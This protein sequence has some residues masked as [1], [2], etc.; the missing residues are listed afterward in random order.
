MQREEHFRR[1]LDALPVPI[2]IFD[3]VQQTFIMANARFCDLIGY[4][5]Q[6]LIALDWQQ[7][8][9]PEHVEFARTAIASAAPDQPIRWHLQKKSGETITVWNKQTKMNLVRNDTTVTE[10]FFVVVVQKPERGCHHCGAPLRNKI[11]RFRG[12]NQN[13]FSPAKRLQ[14]NNGY[15][16]HDQMPHLHR[17]CLLQ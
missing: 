4:T 17:H 7:L 2:F 16:A 9:S 15:H 3:A 1:T 12:R 8:V 14:S 13:T 5:E 6:E 10:A 11:R